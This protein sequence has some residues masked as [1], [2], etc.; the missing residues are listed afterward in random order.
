MEVVV[1]RSLFDGVASFLDVD[2]SNGLRSNLEKSDNLVTILGT[3]VTMND[4]Q[5]FV[6]LRGALSFYIGQTILK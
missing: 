3:K 2:N 5:T 1:V 6:L 4:R